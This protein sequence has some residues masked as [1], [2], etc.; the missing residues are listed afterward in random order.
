MFKPDDYRKLRVLIVEDQPFIRQIVRGMLRKLGFDDIIEARDGQEGMAALF[1]RL[2]D[3]IICDI[4]MKP[5]GGLQFLEATRKADD[6]RVNRIPFLFLTSQD[7]ETTIKA[8]LGSG[9]DGYLLKPVAQDALQARIDAALKAVV[10][11]D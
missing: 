10:R 4:Q 9:V 6:Q 11:R 8:A 2:P 1:R 7:D 3:L 5:M